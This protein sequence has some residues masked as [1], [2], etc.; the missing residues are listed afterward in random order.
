MGRF[1]IQCCQLAWFGPFQSIHSRWTDGRLIFIYL[2]NG[3]NKPTPKRWTVHLGIFLPNIS[4][5]FSKWIEIIIHFH[6]LI[7]RICTHYTFCPSVLSIQNHRIKWKMHSN[8]R[9][10]SKHQWTIIVFL[11][12]IESKNMFDSQQ[13]ITTEVIN[14]RA[15]EWP[16]GPMQFSFEWNAMKFNKIRSN[17][18]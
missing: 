10:N 9:W 8:E 13:L 12:H 14:M 3:D 5:S 6:L 18:K 11:H 4:I 2:S 16:L 1:S 15:L 7:E 17:L